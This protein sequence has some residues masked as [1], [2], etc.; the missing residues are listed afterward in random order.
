[1][2]SK[3][4]SKL[5]PNYSGFASANPKK[6]RRTAKA[7][8]TALIIILVV[9][10]GWLYRNYYQIDAKK[11]PSV[12]NVNKSTKTNAPAS[13]STAKTINDCASN[14]LDQ[15][16]IVSIS[17]RHMWACVGPTQVY[18][19]AV[20]TGMQNLPADLTPVGTYT[21]YAKATNTVLRGSDS[22]GSWNDPVSYWMPFLDNKY[23]IYGFH[24]ATWRSSSD[25]GSISPYSSNASHGC[26]ET[27]LAAAKWLY[28]WSKVGT[29]V[30]IQA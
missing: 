20:I 5:K 8:V 9:M 19:T 22:T 11:F 2:F 12:A 3:Q 18:D 30:T 4:K 26:V 15:N 28:N 29:T 21:I 1:M 27:P 13:D 24:D 25:F 17:Q 14:K 6:H 10:G 16:I 23:G 7:L